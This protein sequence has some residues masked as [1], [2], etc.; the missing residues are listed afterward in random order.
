MA[1]TRQA[2]RGLREQVA[3]SLKEMIPRVQKGK[4]F[5]ER[6]ETEQ[7]ARDIADCTGAGAERLF[8][9]SPARHVEGIA[10]RAS[11]WFGSGT[12]A[13]TYRIDIQILYPRS[14]L[15]DDARADDEQQIAQ[16]MRALPPAVPGVGLRVIEGFAEVELLDDK[17]WVVARL[18]LY[19]V[20]D[21][22]P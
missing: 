19:T 12:V 5:R 8:D 6:T 21:V 16:L 10:G 22:T 4:R 17:P 20:L 13:P 18:P 1:T 14:P 11:D 9:F 3:A 7:Q 2:L 15:W